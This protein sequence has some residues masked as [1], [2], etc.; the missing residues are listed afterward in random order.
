MKTRLAAALVALSLLGSAAMAAAPSMK[1]VS[2]TGQ[3]QIKNPDGSITGVVPGAPLPEIPAGAEIQVL[4]GEAVFQSGDTVVQ[5][6]AGDT[7]SFSA[8][9]AG[10]QVS[11]AAVGEKT[12]IKVV[13]GKTEATLGKGDAVSVTAEAGKASQLA[14]TAGEVSV[15]SDGKAST[16]A[17][18]QSL[19]AAP[20]APAVPAV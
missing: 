15:V 20:A 4:T 18:G 17:A 6:N 14:A 19:A 7:F 1:I 11:I 16:L 8:P 10:G 13:V 2:F 9:A 12:E 5:A 3:I